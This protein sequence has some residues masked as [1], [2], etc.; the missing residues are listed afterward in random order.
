MNYAVTPKPINYI[1][2]SF[3]CKVCKTNFRNGI[4]KLCLDCKTEWEK[5]KSK[6]KYASRANQK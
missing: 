3:F 2:A 6:T 4:S 1:P 5:L